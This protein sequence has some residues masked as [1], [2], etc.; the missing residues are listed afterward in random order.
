MTTL[1]WV[2]MGSLVCG[3][4][5][6]GIGY[7]KNLSHGELLLLAIFGFI[8]IVLVAFLPLTNQRVKT[9]GCEICGAWQVIPV[10][11][12]EAQC[13]QCRCAVDVSAHIPSQKAAKQPGWYM[14]EDRYRWWDGVKWGDWC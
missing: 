9:V 12:T 13:W 5:A 3:I 8:G 14:C 10:A 6:A 1:A 2:A 11:A 4:V 7:R